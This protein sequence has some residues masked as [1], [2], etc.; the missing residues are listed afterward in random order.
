VSIDTDALKRQWQMQS[1]ALLSQMCNRIEL[2]LAW[3]DLDS[4]LTDSV[5]V[6]RNPNGVWSARCAPAEKGKLRHIR[7]TAQNALTVCAGA[8]HD[9]GVNTGVFSTENVRAAKKLVRD[10]ICAYAP[11]AEAG[12]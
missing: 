7:Q 4:L 10:T 11:E 12:G 1:A 5:S 6:I 3:N 2:C 9:R 8:A